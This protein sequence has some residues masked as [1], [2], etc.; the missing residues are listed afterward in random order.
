MTLK[1][2]ILRSLTRFFIIL[3][4]LTRSL[5][6]EK[7][8]VSNRCISGSMSNLIKKSWTV[9][10]FLVAYD[11]LELERWVKEVCNREIEQNSPKLYYKLSE[12]TFLLSTFKLIFLSEWIDYIAT[13]VNFPQQFK[14]I[15]LARKPT[16][17]AICARNGF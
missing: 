13:W 9:S 15:I 16:G 1:L 7:M 2:R 17:Y 6:S 5:F 3:V 10:K 4:R 11:L 12:V 8:L 14:W